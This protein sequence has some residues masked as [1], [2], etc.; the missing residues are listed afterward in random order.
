MKAFLSTI[1]L[2]S[3]LLGTSQNFVSPGIIAFHS[4]AFERT[5][6]DMNKAFETSPDMDSDMRSKAH[7]YRG[8]A[9]LNMVKAGSTSAVIGRNPY[10]IIY[11]DLTKAASLDAKWNET[12]N[13]EMNLIYKQMMSSAKRKYDQGILASTESEI[14]RLLRPAVT[15]LEIA[16]TIKNSFEANH[17]MGKTY[18]ALGI[19]YDQ[20]IDDQSAQAKALSSYELAVNYYEIALNMNA[21]SLDAIRALKDLAYRLGN[22]EQEM[23][24]AQMEENIGG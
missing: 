22:R 14:D 16:V 11:R 23:R 24:Y 17:L 2:F 19:F 13:A 4:G 3:I 8:M 9:R 1:F 6:Q 21:Q 7:Y 20:L 10:L 12:A 15:E 5:I 18:D